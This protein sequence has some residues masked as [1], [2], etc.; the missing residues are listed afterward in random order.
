MERKRKCYKIWSRKAKITNATNVRITI[1]IDTDPNALS[2]SGGSVMVSAQGGG[3]SFETKVNTQVKSSIPIDS[4]KDYSWDC[5]GTNYVTAFRESEGKRLVLFK[6]FPVKAR[7]RFHLTSVDAASSS[8]KENSSKNSGKRWTPEDEKLLQ[9]LALFTEPFPKDRASEVASRFGRSETAVH[10]KW[11]EL[12]KNARAMDKKT[13]VCWFYRKVQ[14]CRN[15]DKCKY[16][17]K[18]A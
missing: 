14:G 10:A 2:L 1:N 4:Q 3:V 7:E 15:G 9:Q 18:N 5:R 8:K 12:L 11:K 6:S 13:P 17:H 16:L